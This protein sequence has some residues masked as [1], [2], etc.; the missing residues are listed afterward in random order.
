MAHQVDQDHELCHAS[1]LNVLCRGSPVQQLATSASVTPGLLLD[2]RAGR[3]AR[4]QF[5]V[6]DVVQVSQHWHAGRP[7][8]VV[9]ASLGV[10]MRTVRKY[11]AAAQAAGIIPGDGHAADRAGWAA[12]VAQWFPE[13]VDA[14]PQR[15]G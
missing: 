14:Q 11:V 13:L 5:Q 9:A 4:R 12:L 7:N 15:R 8:M 2:A 6:I 1:G 10:D 3:T